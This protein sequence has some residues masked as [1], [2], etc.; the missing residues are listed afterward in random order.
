MFPKDAACK[1]ISNEEFKKAFGDSED[2]EEPFNDEGAE[3][4]SNRYCLDCPVMQACYEDALVWGDKY[5]VRGGL[6]ANERFS[7]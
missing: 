2:E 6:P 1:N 4:F 3:Y 7:S 5:G